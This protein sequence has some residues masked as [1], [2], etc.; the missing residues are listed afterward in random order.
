MEATLTLHQA[1]DLLGVDDTDLNRLI[2][3]GALPEAQKA[4]RPEGRVW[5][6]SEEH[7]PAIASR[8]GW[9]IDLRG[10][11]NQLDVAADRPGHDA[12][13]GGDGQPVSE[14]DGEPEGRLGDEAEPEGRLGDEAEPG[15]EVDLSPAGAEVDRP[16]AETESSDIDGGHPGTPAQPTFPV[17]PTAGTQT[18]AA[19]DPAPTGEVAALVARRQ[20]I[21][22]TEAPSASLPATVDHDD[23][24]LAILAKAFDLTLL[25]RL[26]KSHED[27]VASQVKE[28]EARHALAAL[29]DAHNRAT[30]ELEVERRERMATAERFREER[31]ARSVADAKVAELRDRVVR[32]MALA[33]T[34]KHARAEAMS[35]SMRAEREAAN[36]VALL[37]WR[38]RRRYRKLSRPAE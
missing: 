16:D 26:L 14:V 18:G 7:L 4:D 10:G 9:S 36:A 5:V 34:E 28:Q 23:P 31:R 1:G 27:R 30:G 6:I 25:D 17:H 22:T 8:N 32:E 33:D 15:T 37:G 29:N 24:N 21:E 11:P 20:A 13:P 12:S 38:A 3:I 35:R 2:R 19:I